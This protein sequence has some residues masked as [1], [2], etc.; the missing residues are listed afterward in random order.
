MQDKDRI[1]SCKRPITN[2]KPK[3]KAFICQV[4]NDSLNICHKTFYPWYCLYILY[5]SHR[6][7][8]ILRL[9]FYS[10]YP[11]ILLY[12]TFIIAT[13]RLVYR[14]AS[15]VPILLIFLSWNTINTWKL[16]SLFWFFKDTLLYYTVQLISMNLPLTKVTADQK[17]KQSNPFASALWPD[18]LLFPLHLQKT[19]TTACPKALHIRPNDACN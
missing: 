8:N 16:Y 15:W 14:S 1:N 4:L 2:I 18:L 9:I 10:K 12:A 5:E 7:Y 11:V 17:S 6:I 19:T 13:M 3:T